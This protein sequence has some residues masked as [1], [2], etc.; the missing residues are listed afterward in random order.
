[1]EPIHEAKALLKRGLS[2]PV[3]ALIS[4]SSTLGLGITGNEISTERATG[5]DEAYVFKGTSG[6]LGDPQAKLAFFAKP[7]GALAL[8]WRVETNVETNWLLTYVDTASDEI[9]GI[10]D[11]VSAADFQV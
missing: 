11:Y 5:E 10:V 3:S 6:A 7:D 8:T 1:M 9:H 2:D 4:T